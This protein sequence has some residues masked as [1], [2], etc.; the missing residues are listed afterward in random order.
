MLRHE[1]SLIRR[2]RLAAEGLHLLDLVPPDGAAQRKHLSQF[3]DG[4]VLARALRFWRAGW[5]TLVE[6]DAPFPGVLQPPDRCESGDE[7][8]LGVANGT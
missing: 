6:D 2:E 3:H 7:R 8:S 1:V 4:D 5:V